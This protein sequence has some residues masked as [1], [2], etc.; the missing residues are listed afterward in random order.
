[1]KSPRAID[2]GP[3]SLSVTPKWLRHIDKF[4]I[5]FAYGQREILLDYAGINR[6]NILTGILQHGVSQTGLTAEWPFTQ[7]NRAPRLN[8]F[9]RAPVWVYSE[10]TKRHLKSNGIRNVEAIGAP[11]I[12]LPHSELANRITSGNSSH[13]SYLVFPAHFNQDNRVDFTLEEVRRKILFWRSIS[14]GNALTICLYWTEYLSPVWQQVC[15]EEGIKLVTAGLGF[16]TPA[17]SPHLFRVEFL[18]NLSK[19]LQSNTHCIF[20]KESSGLYYAIS[21]GLSVAYFPETRSFEET[22][23]SECHEI[24]INRFPEILNDFVDAEVLKERSDIC[25]G[26]ESFR[27]PTELKSILQYE[28]APISVTSPKRVPYVGRN[29]N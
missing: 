21:L 2:L 11:W 17:W 8:L 27:T 4:S 3:L 26:Q 25:L 7:I 28:Q 12:Y 18:H 15:Q 22:D 23:E 10:N 13:P 20:E 29:L 14:G 24:L 1:M 19:I 16:T 9:H 6:L 5:Q